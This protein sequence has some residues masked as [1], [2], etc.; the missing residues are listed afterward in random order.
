[1]DRTPGTPF[2]SP[3]SPSSPIIIVFFI[4]S[5]EIIPMDISIHTAMGRSKAVPSFLISAGERFTVIRLGGTDTPELRSAVRTLS[6][7][8]LTQDESYPTMTNA[9]SPSDMSASTCIITA[10]MPC[11]VPLITLLNIILLPANSRLLRE[12]LCP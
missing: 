5:S 8:S 7:A 3:F 2:M 11:T 12:N 1:M 9:G 4:A 6:A 10:S